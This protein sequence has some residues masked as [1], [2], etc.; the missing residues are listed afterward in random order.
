MINDTDIEIYKQQIK[1]KISNCLGVQETDIKFI[2]NSTPTNNYL[3]VVPAKQTEIQILNQAQDWYKISSLFSSNL[4]LIIEQYETMF[5]SLFK[6]AIK[7]EINNFEVIKQQRAKEKEDKRIKEE[8]I[9]NTN[10]LLN[11]TAPENVKNATEVDLVNQRIKKIEEN[12]E[13]LKNY[14]I[15]FSKQINKVHADVLDIKADTDVLRSK[16][17]AFRE[18]DR[19]N[20][21]GS[22]SS[23]TKYN[24][25]QRDKS[26]ILYMD[27]FRKEPYRGYVT[28]SKIINKGLN[29]GEVVLSNGIESNIN[30]ITNKIKNR[31]YVKVRKLAPL[32]IKKVFSV[33]ISNDTSNYV[34]FDMNTK[35]DLPKEEF[36]KIGDSIKNQ[37]KEKGLSIDVNMK[38]FVEYSVFLNNELTL[39]DKT[40]TSTKVDTK[41]DKTNK[42]SKKKK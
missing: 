18:K 31:E 32:T 24:K 38:N 14:F 19:N 37:I 29:D 36:D 6:T 41:I 2:P 27:K 1:N 12:Q 8:T 9:N 16:K 7:T 33:L 22:I 34:L 11:M 17:E 4:K 21:Y 3:I 20:K 15:E 5:K 13:T 10:A 30:T 23:I 42:Q 35:T 39:I 26:L 25:S 40:E 28:I